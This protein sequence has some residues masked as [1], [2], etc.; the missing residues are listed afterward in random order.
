MKQRG[1][2]VSEPHK[3]GNKLLEQDGVLQSMSIAVSKV[4]IDK[5]VFQLWPFQHVGFDHEVGS[6]E[7]GLPWKQLSNEL[8]D[9]RVKPLV[10]LEE[11]LQVH[12][13]HKPVEVD[14][15]QVIQVWIIW[16]EDQLRVADHVVQDVQGGEDVDDVLVQSIHNR[17][18]DCES[19]VVLWNF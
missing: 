9:I 18:V 17:E 15:P 16:R 2:F 3:V 7:L 19:G 5:L 11:A 13:V 10:K 14:I 12:S 8:P 1:R 4:H 6:E